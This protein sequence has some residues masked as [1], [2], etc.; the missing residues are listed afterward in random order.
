MQCQNAKPMKADNDFK[1]ILGG[2]NLLYSADISKSGFS[3][4]ICGPPGSGKTTLGL[5]LLHRMYND[6]HAMKEE[7]KAIIL[8]LVEN[9]RQIGA[10]CALYNFKFNGQGKPAYLAGARFTGDIIPD[11]KKIASRTEGGLKKGD[12]LMVDGVSILDSQ[13]FNR[14]AM[15]DFVD[16]IKADRLTA[17]LIAEEYRAHEDIFLQYAADGIIKLDVAPIFNYRRIHIAKLRFHEH[18]L[19]THVFKFKAEND[20]V[21]KAD[22]GILF[23]PSI[24]CLIKGKTQNNHEISKKYKEKG[25]HSGVEGFNDIVQRGGSGSFKVGEQ[26]LLIGPSNTNKFLFGV[27]FLEAAEAEEQSVCVSFLRSFDDVKKVFKELSQKDDS[28]KLCWCLNFNPTDLVIEEMLGGVHNLL[29]ECQSSVTRLF[30][31]GISALRC[32]FEND[33]KFHWFLLSFIR[34]LKKFTNLTAL[35]SYYTPRVFASYSEMDIPAAEHF[36]TVVAFNFQE[37]HNK[38]VPGIVVLQSPSKICDKSLKVPIINSHGRYAVD[39]NAGW[40]RVGMLGGA[41]EQVKEERPFLKLFFQNRSEESVISKFIDDFATRY[42]GDQV[43]KIVPKHN[44]KPDHWSFS[45]Y[46]GAG[47]SNTKLVAL[48]KY[49][50]DMLREKNVLMEVPASIIKHHH[51]RFNEG[52]L[53]KDATAPA[54]GSTVMIPFYADVGVLVFQNNLL[55]LL[56]DIDNDPIP[57]SYEDIISLITKFNELRSKEKTMK[58]LF[59]I[60]NTVYDIQNFVSFFFELCWSFGW[61]FPNSDSIKDNETVCAAL[62]D[63]I[64]EDGF[65]KKAIALLRKLIRR[66]K[67]GAIPNPN[68]GGH[69][70]ESVFSRRWFSKI[71]LLPN[72]AKKRSD[73]GKY[74]IEF[75]IHPLPGID[76]KGQMPGISN[77]DLY[78]IGIIRGALAPET[79]WMLV[80]SLFE[81]PVD[82][83]RVKQKR[84]L[85]IDR[86]AFST[87]LVQN[88]LG[89]RPDPPSTWKDYYSDQDK[90]FADYKNV[91]NTIVNGKDTGNLRY[92]RTCDIPRFYELEETLGKELRRFF[93]DPPENDQK[94]IEDIKRKIEE[95]YLG[96]LRFW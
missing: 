26:V 25:L 88:T 38:L 93:A 17:I 83:E 60:P 71:H 9:E 32:L 61:D 67:N 41:R 4:L 42:P 76:E 46:A 57:Q 18:P 50:V 1:M 89:E 82:V 36:S 56:I 21:K 75:G 86:D 51:N 14:K 33:E 74:S 40:A 10:L 52:F 49:I 87:N 69:Y 34:L 90:I 8:S 11:L 20:A 70:H 79:G 55:K 77:V 27:Q 30:V 62:F 37:Q 5:Y 7:S 81:I 13:G 64:G 2:K 68:Q 6:L 48:R 66:G 91:I 28:K 92:R 45:V 72:D 23:Y 65:F 16:Q 47:H 15:L 80:D 63:W 19:G 58:H 78:A 31:D 22:G 54:L 94:I 96:K 35:V 95:I 85:P 24:E 53:W 3:L 39:L 59:V 44:P 12:L 29:Q 73:S 84:G 43:F